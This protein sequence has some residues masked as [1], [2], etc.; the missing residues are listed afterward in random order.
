MMMVRRGTKMQKTGIRR[1][2]Y[3]AGFII[4][5][6]AI[7]LSGLL[8]SHFSSKNVYDAPQLVTGLGILAVI[9]GVIRLIQMKMQK[10]MDCVVVID[11]DT[12][13]EFFTD[14]AIILALLAMVI[15]ICLIEPKFVQGRVLLDILTQS[16]TRLITALGISMTLLIGG[17]DLSAGRMIG[18][19]AV[20][21]TSMLQTTTYGN[22]FYPGLP[23][24]NI[25]FL[26]PIAIAVLAC[27]IFG[28]LNGVL[29]ARFKLHPFIATLAV[30]VMIYGICS[31]YFDMSPNNSQP[32]GGVR[33]DFAALGQIK[34]FDKLSILV[35]IAAVVCFAVWFLLNKT[36]F[37]K[38][39]YALGG[40][41]EAATVSGVNV[42]GTIIV[43]FVLAAFCYAASGILESA[44][45]AGATNNY[46]NGYELDA[47]AACVV[48]GVSLTGGI[49]KVSGI[50]T[51]VLIF[52]VIQYGLQ[53]VNVSPLWQQ[54]IKGII[55]AIAVALDMSKNSATD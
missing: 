53:F 34:L 22:P 49:G 43:V 5:G 35:P 8:W 26:I 2:Y 30:Q 10:T 21:A 25:S 24:K 55:I 37:G 23:E 6:A 51:G 41:K 39:I 52:T 18:L 27:L 20:V 28:L 31:L 16:S 7:F 47:I 48:G 9:Y 45:T 50:V 46:G 12:V 11:R 42:R 29:V 40:S 3:A 1:A 4:A 38:N 54:V 15:I 13:K 32:I 14:N 44:K 19:A 17:T 33:P 36:T